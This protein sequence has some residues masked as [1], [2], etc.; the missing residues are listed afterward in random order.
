MRMFSG[1]RSR[2]TIPFAV[3]G[4]ERVEDRVNLRRHFV[5]RAR[6]VARHQVCHRSAFGQLHRVPRHFTQVI[7]VEDRDDRR[8]HELRGQPRFTPEARDGRFVL[9]DVRVKHLER[10]LALERE[11]TRAP[12]AAE[13]PLPRKPRIS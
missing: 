1:L 12:D 3:R 6:A 7:P 9:D 4:E 11:I 8:M 10:H 13:R 2:W 5:E